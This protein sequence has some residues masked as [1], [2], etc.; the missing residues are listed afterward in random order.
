[1]ETQK[2][3]KQAYVE[4]LK[5]AMNYTTIGTS[6]LGE[7]GE[8]I[9]EELLEDVEEEYVHAQ[10]IAHHLDVHFDELVS[11]ANNLNMKQEEFDNLEVK[12]RTNEEELIE[13]VERVIKAEESAIKLY[14]TIIKKAE[15]NNQHTTR[16]LAERLLE[17]EE[18]H[19]DQF[20]SY[21]EGLKE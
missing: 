4:E 1:M 15:E 17:D 20:E 21:H 8:N 2:L 13:V 3:L 19:L 10:N 7:K 5:S 11:T 12:Y 6:L 16:R 14:S 18:E 9:G